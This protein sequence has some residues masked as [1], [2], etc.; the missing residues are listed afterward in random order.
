MRAPSEDH[1]AENRYLR[2]CINDLLSVVALPA[3]WSGYEPLRIVET[4]ASTLVSMLDLDFV[5]V[6][7]YEYLGEEPIEIV[8]VAHSLQG[9]L[10]PQE[11]SDLIRGRI[12]DSENPAQRIPN[13]V[14]GGDMGVVMLRLGL[15]G[16]VGFI[17]A[18]S[19]RE[20]F[21]ER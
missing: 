18:G 20:T 4:L 10:S 11:I 3:L 16:E 14:G 9:T 12:P 15:R 13:P 2:R 17:V 21:A 5:Y 19:Q 6:R 1:A 7:L 8:R